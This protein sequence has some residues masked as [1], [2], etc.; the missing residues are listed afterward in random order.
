MPQPSPLLN[1]HRQ[2]ST[3]AMPAA[4]SFFKTIAS[5]LRARMVT[6]SATDIPIRTS[7]V[8]IRSLGEV[9]S[10]PQYLEGGVYGTLWVGSARL[11]GAILIQQD[12][13]SRLISV[14]LG[15]SLEDVN[16]PA[17]FRAL[18]PVERRIAS[19]LCTEV[20]NEAISCWPEQPAPRIQF[21]GLMGSA[22]PMDPSMTTV[23]V[24]SATL[25]FGPSDSPLGLLNLALPVHALDSL[26]AMSHSAAAADVAAPV[27]KRRSLEAVM[28][29]EVELSVELTQLHLTV[30][31][32][33]GLAVGDVVDLG[34]VRDALIKVNGLPLFE[35]QAGVASG[36]RSVKIKRRVQT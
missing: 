22:Q 8:E 2:N 7:M 13:L 19:R 25:D 26:S 14:L 18:S 21:S 24:Y 10:D 23:P 29:V 31:R 34:A 27:K 1:L 3:V 6:R 4:E 5:R 12:L 30:N 33:R 15:Q 28:P 20:L 32:L 16:T 36:V 9:F 17:Q 11:P 35:G